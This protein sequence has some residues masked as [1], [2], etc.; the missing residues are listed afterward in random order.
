MIRRTFLLLV[1]L[2][3]AAPALVRAQPAGAEDK[4]FNANGVKIRYVEAGRGDAV[5]LIHGFASS[6]DGNWRQNG[7]FDAL[8]KDFHVVA[9]DCRGR[10]VPGRPQFVAAVREFLAGHR[11]TE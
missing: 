9:L 5:V 6:L 3:A 2:T 4:F 7:V 10:G 8:A 1:L 11:A